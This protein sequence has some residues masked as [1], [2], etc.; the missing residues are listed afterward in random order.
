[1]KNVPASLKSL[2]T[3]FVRE[4]LVVRRKIDQSL[5]FVLGLGSVD[6][7]IIGFETEAQ[8][9]NY[10]ARVETALKENT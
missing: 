5:R 8:I 4:I 6:M 2:I 9:D 10:M 3:S 7:M 1:M